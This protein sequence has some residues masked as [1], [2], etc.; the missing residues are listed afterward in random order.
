MLGLACAK[1][2]KTAGVES[3]EPSSIKNKI[4]LASGKD[5]TLRCFILVS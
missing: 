5:Q 3:V 1:L 4:V 2:S